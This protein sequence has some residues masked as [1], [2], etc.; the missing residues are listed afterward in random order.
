MVELADFKWSIWTSWFYELTFPEAVAK[1]GEV[2]FEYVEVSAEHLNELVYLRR[3]EAAFLD[4]SSLPRLRKLKR[5][6]GVTS[7]SDAIESVRAYGLRAIHAH[8]P[9]D[10]TQLAILSY[11]DF[12][13]LVAKVGAW[14]EVCAELG[15]DALVLHPVAVSEAHPRLSERVNWLLFDS[16]ARVAGEWG[17]K[18]AIENMDRGRWSNVSDIVRLL[19]SV[20]RPEHMGVC[21][22]TGHANIPRRYKLAPH[23]AVDE[24]A[25]W[26]AATHVSDNFGEFDNHLFPG[27]G[28]IDWADVLGAFSKVGYSAPLNL[29]VPGETEGLSTQE[30]A[31]RLSRY[32]ASALGV[33]S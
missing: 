7:F 24:A 25:S 11:P 10:A 5:Q 22:D 32:A 29:E 8:G 18:V 2:G 30:K 17:V 20:R 12:S 6:L 15:A 19:S 9:F 21:L 16:M 28:T 1:I 14:L 4:V 26:L 23:A 13:E 3:G 31:E 33:R 27:R